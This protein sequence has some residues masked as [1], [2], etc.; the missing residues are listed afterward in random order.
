MFLVQGWIVP[1]LHLYQTL[2]NNKQNRK[3]PQEY[4]NNTQWS[5]NNNQQQTKAKQ[6]LESIQLFFK[7]HNTISTNNNQGCKTKENEKWRINEL[8]LSTVRSME[9]QQGGGVERGGVVRQISI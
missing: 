9:Q 8:I 2:S 1:V 4:I 3:K 6:I 7:T 5:W